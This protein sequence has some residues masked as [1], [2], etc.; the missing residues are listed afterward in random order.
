MCNAIVV[1]RGSC[2]CRLHAVSFD[3]HVQH[4]SRTMRSKACGVP[5]MAWGPV[6]ALDTCFNIVRLGAPAAGAMSCQLH[7]EIV[8]TPYASS[9]TG[10]A[11]E[12][13]ERP[14]AVAVL[15]HGTA[16]GPCGPHWGILPLVFRGCLGSTRGD[17]APGRCGAGGAE[18]STLPQPPNLE[19]SA[20]GEWLGS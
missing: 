9:C 6:S 2:A 12:G 11:L 10:G 15:P 17:Y 20:A 3:R 1:R 5:G 7:R 18:C 19:R 4:V 13:D 14:S 16:E 8:V